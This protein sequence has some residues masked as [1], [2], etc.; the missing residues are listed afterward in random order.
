[1]PMAQAENVIQNAILEYL[2]IRGIFCWRNNNQPTYDAKTKRYRAKSKYSL[3]G[4]PDILGIL[5]DGR[6]LGIEV[7]TQTGRVSDAQK[8]FIATGL[9]NNA[10]VFVARSVGDVIARG[11]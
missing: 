8:V 9:K 7:K 6:F 4:I 2:S 11:L 5:P 3:N 10:L 1:M